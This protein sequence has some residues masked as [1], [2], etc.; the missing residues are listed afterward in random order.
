MFK[1]KRT[2]TDENGS[3]H[4]IADIGS[5]PV[6]CTIAKH[7]GWPY[8]RIKGPQLKPGTSIQWLLHT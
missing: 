3:R 5:V 7:Y 1:G 4:T 2:T 6:D 8:K